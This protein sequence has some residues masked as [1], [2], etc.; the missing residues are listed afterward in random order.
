MKIDQ[1][2]PHMAEIEKQKTNK[3]KSRTFH[4]DLS[5]FYI[6][7]RSTKY[8]IYRQQCKGKLVLR[9]SGKN[10]QLYITDSDTR[11]S[12]LKKK[13]AVAVLLQQWLREHASVTSHNT[14]AMRFL[15]DTSRTF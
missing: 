4:E 3:K 6:L 8:C 15:C 1:E 11:T 13:L 14:A 2:N 10:Q 12:T 7:H 5:I 9:F